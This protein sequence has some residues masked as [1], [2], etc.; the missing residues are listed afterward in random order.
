MPD[1]RQFIKIGAAAGVAT[2]GSLYAL[3][4]LQIPGLFASVQVPQ[5]PLLGADIP[6]YTDPL[7]TFVGNRVSA[8][9]FNVNMLEFQ[10][11]VLPASFYA[12]LKAPFQA[13]TYVWGYKVDSKPANYPGFTVEAKRN[14][15]TQITYI[16]NLPYPNNSKLEPDLTIDQTIHWADPFHQM[17]STQPYK[18]VIPTVVHLHGAEVA[19][20]YD[21]APEAWFTQD[22]HHGLGYST[23]KPTSANA[24]IYQYPNTQQATTL[25]F[26]DHALGMTRINV[27]SGLAAF[28][29]LRDQFDTGLPGN[30]LGLPAGP[31]E[32]ELL[33]Q[34]RQFDTNGQLLFPDGS[35]AANPTGLNGPP[36]NPSIH[37]FWIPEFFGDAMVVNGKTWPFL[38]V[39]P[40]RYRFR[41]LNAS[42][43]RFL[44][45]TTVDSSSQAAGPAFWQIG[46]DGGLLDRPALLNDPNSSSPLQLFLA[47]SERADIIIDFSGLAGRTFTLTNSAAFPFP[48]GGPPDPA[49]DGQIMQFRVNLPLSSKDTTYNP[50]SGAPLRGGANQEPAIVRLANPAT[51]TLAA[52]VTPNAKRQLILVEV[53]GPGGPIE[54]LVNNSK[55]NG[56]REG[57]FTPI[58][59]SSSDRAGQSIFLTELPRLSSTEEWEIMNLTQDAHP[60]HIH[61]IQFQL[62]N[63]QN[64]DIDNY[65]AL[66]DSQFPGGTFNGLKPDGT[67]GPIQYPAGVYIPGYGPPGTY[68]SPNTNGAIGGN[69]AFDPF[70]QGSIILPD[71]NEIG[72]KDTLKMYPG[73]V[74]R[75]V[76]RFAPIS[77]PVGAPKLG[78]NPYV[79]D[80]TVGPGYVWHCHILDHEDNEM[81]RPYQPVF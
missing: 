39:E 57:T 20:F 36:P 51:G 7:P 13:G 38:N 27:F 80:P 61:L 35:P 11:K 78:Q 49:V 62:I 5:T 31:Q 16:N 63:R 37:P 24:A 40:R 67:W 10:Q 44:Q 14:T 64:A 48:S 79:F 45:M 65:R 28:Y 23:L 22:G 74:T 18:G 52:G 59:G 68:T 58:P 21:G 60:I 41:F 55:W 32:I 15:T 43:A 77:L 19:S 26:H 17:G 69:P 4:R 73:M 71:A 50:A 12:S 66:Y 53:E 29:L 70:L 9:T 72:W 34:D 30:P 2:A 25:W 6:K 8:A 76:I 81:M 75:I 1:R 3:S 46:T 56:L 42:N 33:I 47:P 54:V